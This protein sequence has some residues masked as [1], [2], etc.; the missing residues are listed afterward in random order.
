M[1]CAA[2]ALSNPKAGILRDGPRHA[3]RTREGWGPSA[4]A[5]FQDERAESGSQGRHLGGGSSE[6]TFSGINFVENAAEAEE[7]EKSQASANPDTPRKT[8]TSAGR[9]SPCEG[10]EGSRPWTTS[11]PVPPG[12]GSAE[13]KNSSGE[14]AVK[15]A[16][17][18]QTAFRIV[19]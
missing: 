10:S 6:S 19:W 7:I 16:T 8:L 15:S 17:A 5:G 11:D 1:K 13:V 9:R 2:D 4:P 3:G 12:S 18:E 14:A